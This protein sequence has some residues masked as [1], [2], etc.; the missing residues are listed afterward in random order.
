MRGGHAAILAALVA[1]LVWAAFSA[2]AGSHQQPSV[3]LPLVNE[4]NLISQDTAVLLALHYLH[5]G[6]PSMSFPGEPTEIRGQVMP[7]GEAARLIVPSAGLPNQ[8]VQRPM[9]VFVVRGDVIVAAPPAPG[10]PQATPQIYHQ[11]ALFFDAETG[12]MGGWASYR[13]GRELDASALPVLQIPPPDREVPPPPTL[14][15][16]PTVSPAPTLPP[17]ATAPSAP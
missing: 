17:A 11:V 4:P 6:R 5:G 3:A 1:L 16:Y 12:E 15:T 10:I 2:V 13:T 7:F 14:P 8:D 9:W